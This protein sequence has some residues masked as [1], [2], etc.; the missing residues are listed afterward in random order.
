MAHADLLKSVTTEF[1]LVYCWDCSIP[2][3]LTKEKYDRCKSHKENFFCPNGHGA[4]F[5]SGPVEELKKQLEDEKQ[6]LKWAQDSRDYY[7]RK[8]KTL[9]KSRAAIKG[10]LTRVRNRIKH[11]VCP[12]C[13]RTFQDLSRHMKTKH[14]E[15]KPWQHEE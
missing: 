11:G 7:Q 8:T 10:Q 6:K 15:F 13:T 14:P 12:C 9:E 2:Y 1:L 5:T 4:V 3:Y